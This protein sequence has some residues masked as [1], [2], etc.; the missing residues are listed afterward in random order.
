MK[1][2]RAAYASL[3]GP[4][5]GDRVRL[6]DTNLFLRIERDAA[7]YGE[8]VTFGGGKVIRDGQGQ[9][10]IT[11]DAG[12]PDLVITNV[13]VLDYWGVVKADVG[14]RDGRICAIGKAGNPDVQDCVTAGLAIG[15]TTE[16]IAGEHKILTAGGIDA[17]I[18]FISPQQVWEAL[19]SGVTTMIGGGT[20]PADGTRA[21]TCTPGEWNLHRMLEAVEGLPLNFGFLGKGNASDQSALAEQVRAGAMG[22]KLHEDWG[23]TP[24]TI[25]T[26]LSV[27][28]DYDVQIAI[29]TDTL[30]ESGF[31]EDT[32]AAFKEIGRAS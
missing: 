26:A 14:V 11:R 20:G 16:I 15:P 23:T 27:A 10:Q 3:C 29:H 12:A 31:V 30:N 25:D 24:A 2:R 6:A 19:Y 5:A 4:T 32:I 18:H 28:D 17:H 21:T 7:I 13:I 1:V 22:L 9:S 8:E